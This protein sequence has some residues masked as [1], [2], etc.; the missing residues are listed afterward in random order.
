[1]K[2]RSQIGVI[3][4]FT[5]LWD[6]AAILHAG[7]QIPWRSW[8]GR[9][10]LGETYSYNVS[11][12][13][14]AS[15]Y[16][17]HGAIPS[18]TVFDGYGFTRKP[19]PHGSAQPDWPSTKRVYAG[20]HGTLWTTSVEGLKEYR[21]G[22]WTVRYTPAAGHRLM[23]AAPSGGQVILLLEDSVL[24]FDPERE[25]WLE[26]RTAGSSRITPFLEICPGSA[27]EWYVAGEHGLAKLQISRDGGPFE[28]HEVNGDADHLAHFSHPLPGDSEL[29][30]QGISSRGQRH[31]IVRW[32]GANLETVYAATADNLRGWRGGD[33]TVW[34]V[35]G[36]EIF[37][38][39]EGRKY[40]VERAG[41][42]SGSIFDVY[43][44]AGKAFWVATS[45]GITRYAPALWQRPAGMEEF[46]SPVHAIAEDRDGRLWMSA[47]DYVLELKGDAWTRYGLPR[48]LRTKTVETNSLAPLADG[49]ILVQVVSE[50]RTDSILALN[51][52]T[53][54]FTG[55]PHPEGRVIT[56]LTQRPG[57]G[58]WVG[59]EVK[60]IPGFRLEVYDGASLRR[61]LQLGRE[62]TGANLRSIL[63]RKTGEIWLGGSAGGGLYRNGQ[64][65]NPF[66]SANG[67]SDV[68]VFLLAS[69][70]TGE[71]VAGGRDQILKYDGKSWTAMRTG[72]DRVRH[73][74]TQRDGTLW[75]A[76][77]LGVH[78]LKDGS[79]INHQVEE[80]LPTAIACTIFLDSRNRLW[81][82]TSR[83]LVLYHPSA[84]M[85][86]PQTLL[87]QAA[88]L[89]EAP[90]SGEARI[91][92]SGIDKWSQTPSDRLL[93]S[94]RLDA[95]KWSQFQSN[96]GAAYDHLPAGT[97]SFDVR[98]MDR[99]GNI[100]PTGQS[101]QFA[102]LRPLYRQFGFL[103]LL[104]AA[105][106]A[107]FVLA[108]VVV[109]QYRRRSSLIAE[110]DHARE[111][112]EAASRHKT[113]FLANMSHEIRTPMNGVIGM[114]SLL[115]DT[116]QTAEQREY[117]STVRRSGEALLTIINDIL[118]FSK[119]EAGKLAIEEISF[120]LRL[121]IEDVNEMLAPKIEER[122]L[123]LVLQYP[124]EAPSL[125]VGD[126]GRIRQVMTNLV[127]NA[128]K[129][130]G[131]GHI[132]V[133]VACDW[134]DDVRAIMRIS[135]QDTGVGIP[136]EKLAYVFEEFSQVDSSTTRKYGGTGLGL[137]ISK[138]LVEL[139][140]GSIEVSSWPGA[141]STFSLTLPLALDRQ[142]NTGPVSMDGLYNLQILIVDDNEINRRVLREQT[143]GWGMRSRS[144]EGAAEALQA[145]RRAKASGD[146]YHFVLLDYQMPDMDGPEPSRQMR[147]FATRC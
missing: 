145:L 2:N 42:L 36:T 51:P 90:P 143:T 8:S 137:A 44:E 28:W 109:S 85:D 139:M 112:A 100:D 19:D 1:M 40:P 33:D 62:W 39:R 53:G 37:R 134:Q 32:R 10:G 97:H 52:A 29:F 31:V 60:G 92:F 74:T 82:G 79:W 47:T 56:Q 5:A 17:R 147:R 77:A 73:L 38:L 41:V 125:F 26:I 24:E 140:G 65:S 102:V 12:M 3:L 4:A 142:P 124:V 111:L 93:F 113:E 105:S 107:I 130:T 121:T 108:S 70:P 22:K 61:V 6:S 48:G 43:S 135:V 11:R 127:G 7:D 122:H 87:N 30:A 18:M 78:R 57:G 138:R 91:A 63:E 72:L 76:S 50:D 94:Y 68:G 106:C 83:G 88:N 141:G 55:W 129:F 16:I 25:S 110:L 35:E 46:D 69:L 136:A 54:R 89:R 98:S 27:G 128:V 64:F 80:G 104:G 75:V 118:D 66:Q 99:N 49:R 14:G 21:D 13:P 126:S 103:A 96:D 58:V 101:H 86:A 132:V 81:A 23:A 131:R 34:I 84:D 119:V 20:T 67:Y 120:D 15:A 59:S 146:P 116:E 114:A 45:E 117:A 123:E 115:L 144:F 71:L 95:G 9:N 133:T